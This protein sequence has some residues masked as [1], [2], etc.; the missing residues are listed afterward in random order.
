MF[1]ENSGHIYGGSSSERFDDWLRME[2]TFIC[3]LST[4]PRDEQV[5][6][7]RSI[8]VPDV[9]IVDFFASEKRVYNVDKAQGHRQV[10]RRLALS[11]LHVDVDIIDPKEC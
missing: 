2:P 1:V 5:H 8:L 9:F 10:E 7:R 6:G 3:V 4:A 11:V